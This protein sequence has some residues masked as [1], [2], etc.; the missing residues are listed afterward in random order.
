M[1]TLCD[2][3]GGSLVLD[4]HGVANEQITNRNKKNG[5]SPFRAISVSD[6]KIRIP[7]EAAATVGSRSRGGKKKP[8]DDMAQTNETEERHQESRERETD[9]IRPHQC[10]P[11][12]NRAITV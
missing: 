3:N 2:N 8:V 1:V 11:E 7:L 6:D 12:S 10:H 5:G 4:S 9:S